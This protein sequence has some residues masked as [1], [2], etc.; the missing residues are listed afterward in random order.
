MI[1]LDT[2]TTGIAETDRL[3]E[4]A[5]CTGETCVNER[6]KPP[7]PISV[8]AMSITHI[9]NEM[10]ANCLPF[11]GS[12]AHTELATRFKMG[13]IVVAHNAQFDLKMLAR[14]GL[15]PQ[16]HICTLKLAYAM[17]KKAEWEKYNLQFLRYKFNLKMNGEIKPHE[18]LSDVYV[19][20]ELF[21]NIFNPNFTLQQML[22]ISSKPILFPKMMFGKHKGKFFR[23]IARQDLDYLMWFR[24]SG[25]NLDEN[26]LHTL[27]HWI[28]NR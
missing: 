5:Y 4:I 9:T 2:E 28:N 12:L 7:V 10:V 19:L 8:D 26:M 24:R 27:N 14:E 16:R 13:E 11:Q 23:D 20:Q 3:C 15:A 17:D 21:Y 1:F 18:A 22:E 6:F 25:D